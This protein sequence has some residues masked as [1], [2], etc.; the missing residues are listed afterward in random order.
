M[1][2]ETFDGENKIKK[3]GGKLYNDYLTFNNDVYYINWFYFDL[4]SLLG[5]SDDVNYIIMALQSGRL[6]SVFFEKVE[7]D[8]KEG[9]VP[10]ERFISGEA[11]NFAKEHGMTD[12]EKAAKWLKKSFRLNLIKAYKDIGESY[13]K[14][15]NLYPFYPKHNHR[16]MEICGGALYATETQ[17]AIDCGKFIEI[18]GDHL[19]AS[20]SQS[21][22]LHQEVADSINRFFNG[23]EI[24]TSELENY[25]TLKD[26]IIKTNPKSMKREWYLRL[27][28]RDCK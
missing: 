1:I 16:I 18:Y 23:M 2:Q 5:L 21:G 14:E 10:K 20:V 8:I 11:M 28:W 26:G 19:S 13:L 17:L 7:S 22:K 4:F 24:T 3:I 27:G 6:D 12:P 25:F 9:K 15:N